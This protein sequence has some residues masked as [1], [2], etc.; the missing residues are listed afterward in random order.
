MGLKKWLL[1]INPVQ[2]DWTAMI[3][4]KNIETWAELKNVV[5]NTKLYA[6]PIMYY[7]TK[8]NE[9]YDGYKVVT[10]T[11]DVPKFALLV[12]G[13]GTKWRVGKQ[14]IDEMFAR[15]GIV[16]EIE[17]VNI[18]SKGWRLDKIELF[19]GKCFNGQIQPFQIGYIRNKLL[20]SRIWC[21]F[22]GLCRL[23]SSIKRR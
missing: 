18:I 3:T 12:S 23:R 5:A 2:L 15:Y 21:I 6:K 16:V 1:E 7:D 13:G 9:Q 22:Q 14:T 19:G 20:G 10:E 4:L 8:V 17:S 11:T